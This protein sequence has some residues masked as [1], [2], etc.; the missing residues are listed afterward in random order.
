MDNLIY[1]IDRRIAKLLGRKGAKGEITYAKV[2]ELKALRIDVKYD[3]SSPQY[4]YVLQKWLREKH[5]IH[6]FTKVFYDSLLNKNT[7][8]CDIMHIPDGKT[9][10]SPR[11]DSY[12]EALEYALGEGLKM[13]KIS[14]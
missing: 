4:Q 6:M 3:K 1:L 2:A 14:K 10:R 8:A 9:A 13:I 12:E 11:L 5:N 7:Y